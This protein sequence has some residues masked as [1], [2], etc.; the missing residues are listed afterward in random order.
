MVN[1]EQEIEQLK[2]EIKRLGSKNSKG[3]YYVKYLKI[4]D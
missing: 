4:E 2:A 1:V 3:N